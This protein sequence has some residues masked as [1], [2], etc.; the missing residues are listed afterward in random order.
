MMARGGFHSFRGMEVIP[1]LQGAL[2]EWTDFLDKTRALYVNLSDACDREVS[3]Y[4][5]QL[6]KWMDWIGTEME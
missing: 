1:L 2:P 4:S 3:E 6:V 5:D